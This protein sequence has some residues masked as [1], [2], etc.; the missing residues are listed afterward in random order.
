MTKPETRVGNRIREIRRARDITLQTLASRTG[1]T[2]GYLSKLERGLANPP[3]AT[4][5]SIAAAL[6][7]S[8]VDLL[9]ETDGD[10]RLSIV[11]PDER[12][13]VTRDGSTYGYH[14]DALAYRVRNKVMDP[15]LITMTPHPTDNTMFSHAGEEMLYVLEGDIQFF[16]GEERHLLGPGTCLY[17]D[18]SIPHRAQCAGE[19]PARALVVIVSRGAPKQRPAN[20]RN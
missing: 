17:F 12:R 8:V 4:L 20:F 11:P 5:S 2:T 3:I 1:L 19:R 13:P 9:D 18:A 14:Y 10:V 15:F 7:N 6:G 16:H